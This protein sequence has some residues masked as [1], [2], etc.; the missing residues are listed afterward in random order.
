MIVKSRPATLR[1]IVPGA[2]YRCPNC[3][4]RIGRR[5]TVFYFGNPERPETVKQAAWRCSR[6][7]TTHEDGI[8]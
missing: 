4:R 1:E 5:F 3:R 2:P 7:W 8:R 6:C